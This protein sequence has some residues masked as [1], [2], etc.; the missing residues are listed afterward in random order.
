MSSLRTVRFMSQKAA[1]DLIPMA[2]TAL[3]SITGPAGFA[4]LKNGWTNLLR[5]EFHDED[6]ESF[7]GCLLFDESLAQRIF[8]FMDALPAHVEHVC[9]HCY[10]GISRSAAVAKF[11]A[12]QHGVPFPESYSLY[13][14]LVYGTLRRVYFD[15]VYGKDSAEAP[16]TSHQVDHSNSRPSSGL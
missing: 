3:I 9:V 13:N 11:L 8:A 12:E 5:L 16:N 10:A 1:S 4:P 14:K 7:E 15:D 6:V 2:D